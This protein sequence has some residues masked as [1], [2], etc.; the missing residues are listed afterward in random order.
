[1]TFRAS[2]C[3][4]LLTIIIIIWFFNVSETQLF[5]FIIMIIILHCDLISVPVILNVARCLHAKFFFSFLFSRV[6]S[7]AK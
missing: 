1:M 7:T 3:I 5:L 6:Q 4:D 2:Y